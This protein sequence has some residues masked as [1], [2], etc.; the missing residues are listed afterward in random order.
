M[1]P[2]PKWS[3]LALALLLLPAIA[4]AAEQAR[5]MI[6]LTID[7]APRP[8]TNHFSGTERAAKLIAALKASRVP[9]VMFFSNT[10]RLSPY[11]FERMKFYAA[12]GHSIGNH[13]HTHPDLHRVGVE[14]FVAN[15]KT[16]DEI[17]RAL[18]GYARWFR[19]PFLRE[20]KTVEERNAVRAALKGIGYNSAYV[21]VDTYDWYMDS[22]L[23]EALKAGKAVDFD[24][25]GRAYVDLMTESIEFYDQVAQQ[26]LGRSPKHVLLMHENDLAALF[27]DDLVGRLRSNG[28]DIISAEDAFTDPIA[29]S[30]PETLVLGQGR[31]IALAIDSGYA[32]QTRM[33]EDEA[34]IRA[35]FE[36][37]KVWE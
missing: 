36:R 4:T 17:L 15:I 23:Q 7:D 34:K 16:A 8:D 31:V 3:A 12:A 35:E 6:A 28:W 14:D 2:L 1:G 25:L 5:R 26:T 19:F 18:P 27:V 9:K 29:A 24:R 21:T 32:G 30:E 37:R 33:W 20:G 11:D 10:G 22:L 13:S